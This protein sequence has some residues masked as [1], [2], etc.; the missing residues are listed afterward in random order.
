MLSSCFG[1]HL[2][3]GVPGIS[4]SHPIFRDCLSFSCRSRLSGKICFLLSFVARRP[5]KQ[6]FYSSFFLFDIPFYK[7]KVLLL[8][9]AVLELL[10]EKEECVRSFCHEQYP[11]GVFI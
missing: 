8:D 5:A 3:E 4:F 10:L 1:E 9:G 7:A 2:Q 6:C 11:R